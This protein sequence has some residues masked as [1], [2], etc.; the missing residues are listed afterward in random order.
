MCSLSHFEQ[1]A[2]CLAPSHHQSRLSCCCLAVLVHSCYQDSVQ[3]HWLYARTL[4][5]DSMQEHWM[6]ART[7]TVHQNGVFPSDLSS[8]ILKNF[9]LLREGVRVGGVR[10]GWGGLF[11]HS[12]HSNLLTPP[13]HDNLCYSSLPFYRLYL[14]RSF[15]LMCQLLWI[16]RKRNLIIMIHDMSTNGAITVSLHHENEYLSRRYKRLQLKVWH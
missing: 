10:V 15:M 14:E 8:I 16:L 4:T 3:E 9:Q 2:A 1:S 12:G 5:L 6:Y 7:L 13:Q 11:Y